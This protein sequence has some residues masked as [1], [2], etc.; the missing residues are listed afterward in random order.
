VRSA[1]NKSTQKEECPK[2]LTETCLL[3]TATT[4]ARELVDTQPDFGQKL[5]TP[6]TL[7]GMGF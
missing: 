3:A 2:A 7:V 5:Y 6:L 4:R 1:Q